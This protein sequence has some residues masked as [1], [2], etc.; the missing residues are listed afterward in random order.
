VTDTL[1]KTFSTTLSDEDYI[2]FKI[3]IKSILKTGS[4]TV[5]FIKKDGAERKM[6]CTLD[7]E[8]VPGLAIEE[9]K[10]EKIRKVSEE[11]LAV[12]DLEANAWRSFRYD[13]VKGVTINIGADD[14]TE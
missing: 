12:Y 9:N 3:W 5:E 11:E 6:L 13:S 8:L 4:A 2:A 1:E 14:E 10:K 7:P